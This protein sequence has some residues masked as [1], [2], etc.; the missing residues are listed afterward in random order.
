MYVDCIP[1]FSGPTVSGYDQRRHARPD[2]SWPLPHSQTPS[3]ADYISIHTHAGQPARA[4][5][6]RGSSGVNRTGV[7]ERP[8]RQATNNEHACPNRASASG[9]SGCSFPLPFVP[10]L[11]LSANGLIRAFF[12]SAYIL[13]CSHSGKRPT[14][15]YLQLQANPKKEGGQAGGR[16]G[17]QS[18]CNNFL[19]PGWCGLVRCQSVVYV[20][21]CPVE[22][23]K[24]ERK[25]ARSVPP[26]YQRHRDRVLR[27]GKRH[28]QEDEG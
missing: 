18:R 2:P 1:A 21:S 13:T 26:L 14:R 19:S 27:V 10:L 9:V 8:V 6:L 3:H 24:K 5:P 12:V 17:G 28:V 25:R 22:E 16:A 7:D 20:A 23:R 15:Q 4:P 11:S